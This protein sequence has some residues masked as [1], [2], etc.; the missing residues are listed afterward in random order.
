MK[1][2][3]FRPV[4]G[5][6]RAD[7]WRAGLRARRLGAA[8]L[9][10]ALAACG[11][12]APAAGPAAE[13][14]VRTSYE[15]TVEPASPVVSAPAEFADVARLERSLRELLA[16]AGRERAELVM[17]LEFEPDGLNTRRMVISHDLDPVL[18]DSAQKLVF[19]SLVRA[20]ASAAPWGTRLR[21]RAEPEVRLS[22]EPRRY[23]PPRPRSTQLEASM[24]EFMGSGVRYR[25]GERERIVLLALRVHP[26]GYVQDARVLRGAPAGGTVERDLRDYARQFSFYPASLDGVPVPGEIAVPV[27]VRG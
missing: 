1:I 7:G 20:P 9:A 24:A 25:N 13:M 23:C 5:G 12:P 15:C 4:G 27:R 26:A 10:V 14:A 22:L 8:A 21:I 3:T 2:N 6:T 18:S 19:A 16:G 11:N 17:T